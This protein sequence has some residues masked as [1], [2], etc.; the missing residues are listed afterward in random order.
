MANDEL[1][2]ADGTQPLPPAPPLGDPLSGLVTGYLFADDTA[3]PV[4]PAEEP[5]ARA[6]AQAEVARR[7]TAAP[8]RSVRS[9]A[10]GAVTP[11]AIPLAESLPSRPRQVPR[12]PADVRRAQPV[13]SRPTVVQPVR[14]A[15]VT[16]SPGVPPAATGS[17][18]TAGLGCAVFVI[19]AVL[20]VVLFVV[21][22]AVYGHGNAG[23]FNG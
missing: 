20:L 14:Q 3:A 21:L 6:R 10:P 18:R 22:G 19:V 17:R 1:F 15:S 12:A 7:R 5:V 16:R 2:G 4:L 23:F 9:V 13:P 11:D 8:S